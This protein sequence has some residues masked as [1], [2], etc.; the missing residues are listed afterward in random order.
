MEFR[1]EIK[2]NLMYLILGLTYLSTKYIMEFSNSFNVS[3]ITSYVTHK[4]NIW[5]CRQ[6][7]AK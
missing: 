7:F 2:A 6:R 1:C 4:V 5:K 3:G